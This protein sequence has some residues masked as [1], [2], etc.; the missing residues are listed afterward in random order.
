MDKYVDDED[1]KLLIMILESISKIKG[2]DSLRPSFLNV[3][4]LVCIHMDGLDNTMG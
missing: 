4:M 1:T 3:N 2:S